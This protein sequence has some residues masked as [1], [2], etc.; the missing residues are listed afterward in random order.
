MIETEEKDLA[1]SLEKYGKIN[2]ENKKRKSL[3]LENK[4]MYFPNNTSHRPTP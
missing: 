2:E 3:C 1:A 4:Q